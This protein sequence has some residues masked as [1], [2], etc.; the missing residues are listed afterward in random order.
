MAQGLKVGE[1]VRVTKTMDVSRTDPAYKQGLKR[2]MAGKVGQV[3]ATGPGHASITVEFD[4]K[5][6]SLPSRRLDRVQ[7][8]EEEAPTQESASVVPENGAG[9]TGEPAGSVSGPNI[10]AAMN[11]KDPGFLTAVANMLLMS[12]NNPDTL[13]V[14]LRLRDL[15][16]ETQAQVEG[17]V[18]AKLALGPELGKTGGIVERVPKRRGRPPKPK[19]VDGQ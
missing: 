17:L 6:V 14:Q 10:Y 4:G 8:G 18:R 9:Q 15:P 1:K 5:Q 19:A 2:L 13:L 3:V 11:F 12:G 7:A 16:S